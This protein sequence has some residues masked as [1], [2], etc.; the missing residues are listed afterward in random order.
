MTDLI[1][2]HHPAIEFVD[3]NHTKHQ[4][5]LQGV[6]YSRAETVVA[7]SKSNNAINF[8]ITPP[9][10]TAIDRN[11][12]LRLK[13]KVT[14]V[15]ATNVNKEAECVKLKELRSYPLS[16]VIQNCN[17]TLNG[18]TMSHSVAELQNG[19]QYVNNDIETRRK[20]SKCPNM[21]PMLQSVDKDYLV[22]GVDTASGVAGANYLGLNTH[23]VDDYVS[24]AR[25]GTTGEFVLDLVEPLNMPILSKSLGHSLANVSQLDIQ[26]T[27]TS[28]YNLFKNDGTLASGIGGVNV[29]FS[30]EEASLQV[31]YYSINE[32]IPDEIE[33]PFY[34][35]VHF[36][37][38]LGAVVSNGTV[39]T[40]TLSNFKLNS[41]PEYVMVFASPTNSSKGS[42]LGINETTLGI[43]N[44]KLTINNNGNLLDT[45]SKENLWDIGVSNGLSMGYH[46]FKNQSSVFLA[47]VNK[48]I[49]VNDVIA[50]SNSLFNCQPTIT[51]GNSLQDVSTTYEVHVVFL[52]PTRAVISENNCDLRIGYSNNDIVQAIDNDEHQLSYSDL[53]LNNHHEILG[54]SLFGKVWKGLKKVYKTGKG[55][56]DSDVGRFAIGQAE[57]LLGAGDIKIGG[58]A[59]TDMVHRKRF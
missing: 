44:V 15:G 18:T 38:D 26:L 11:I 57:N 23:V 25:D 58:S 59:H 34:N 5:I 42:N 29:S 2:V 4:P 55:V 9:S 6:N 41:V 35:L 48:D 12:N 49:N 52:Q 39:G 14:G 53:D 24:S 31:L 50:G 47:R 16:N 46:Q 22:Q 17:L 13:V 40:K 10:N 36:K 45:M 33:M 28:L 32:T 43:E 7:S 1:S 51:F 54:G 21:I 3:K 27:L 8:S 56:V 20:N 37:Q 30:V 19:V